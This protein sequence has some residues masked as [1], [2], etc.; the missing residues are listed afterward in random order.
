MLTAMIAI[1]KCLVFMVALWLTMR[2]YNDAVCQRDTHGKI[3]LA[4]IFSWGAWALLSAIYLARV[5]R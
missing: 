3:M 2:I 4:W 1:F 5:M